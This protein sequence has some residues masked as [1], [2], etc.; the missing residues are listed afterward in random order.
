MV[1]Q[2]SYKKS[3]RDFDTGRLEL[4][5]EGLVIQTLHVGFFDN[6]GSV[7]DRLHHQFIPQHGLALSS[8]Q[9]EIYLSDFRKTAADKLKT[10]YVNQSPSK[11]NSFEYCKGYSAVTWTAEWCR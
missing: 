10:V 8:K 4:L 7:L 6:E 2:N 11:I 9:H 5:A 1:R 3:G